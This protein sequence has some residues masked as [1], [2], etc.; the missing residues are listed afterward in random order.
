MNL[1]TSLLLAILPSWQPDTPTQIQEEMAGPVSEITQNFEPASPR[2][3]AIFSIAGPELMR[4]SQVSDFIE[5]EV[6]ELAYVNHGLDYADFSI[7]KFQMKPSFIEQLEAHICQNPTL[8]E[9][10]ASLTVYD[11]ADLKAVRAERLQRIKTASYQEFILSAFHDYCRLVYCDYLDNATEIEAISFMGTAY[12]LGFDKSVKEILNYQS[13][14]RFPYGPRYE[15]T[16]FAFGELSA[17]IY[18]QLIKSLC[19]STSSTS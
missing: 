5:T 8:Y 7:G 13:L 2:E 14:K 4:Y 9:R 10:Y 1:F 12:N 3:C 6:L 11:H 17:E 16:Q 15:G 19:K 18:T